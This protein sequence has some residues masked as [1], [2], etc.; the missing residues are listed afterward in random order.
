MEEKQRN[1]K[2]T[3]DKGKYQADSFG[4]KQMWIKLLY[5]LGLAL[6]MEEC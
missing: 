4:C 3:R 2:K 5:Q 6:D 1:N